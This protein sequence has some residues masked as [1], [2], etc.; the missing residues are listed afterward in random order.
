MNQR[1]DQSA[2]VIGG[3]NRRLSPWLTAE[4]AEMLVGLPPEAARQ[5]ERLIHQQH[6]SD[7]RFRW[8]QS[9]SSEEFL[10]GTFATRQARS[11]CGAGGGIN[12]GRIQAAS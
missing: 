9:S 6:R 3:I 12:R 5:M 7:A 10:E 8:W 11:W 2:Y 4:D 1:A